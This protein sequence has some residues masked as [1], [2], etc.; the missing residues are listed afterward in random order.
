MGLQK[1]CELK[2]DATFRSSKVYNEN[3]SHD[4]KSENQPLQKLTPKSFELIFFFSNYKIK[5]IG[6][7]RKFGLYPS[8]PVREPI[9]PLRKASSDPFP[10]TYLPLSAPEL[11]SPIGH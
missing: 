4:G 9:K 6:D 3:E 10:F 7:L 5:K 11:S 1:K 8:P 2:H